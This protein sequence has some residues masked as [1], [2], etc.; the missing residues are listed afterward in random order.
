MIRI[1]DE[2]EV[3]EAELL[4]VTSRSSGPGGQNV[5]KVSTRVT[6]RFDVARSPALSEDERRLVR[7]RLATRINRDG[8]LSVTS[9]RHRTQAGNRRAAQERFVELMAEALTVDP[10]RR[11][12]RTPRAARARRLDEK[13][14][15]ARLKQRRSR[16]DPDRE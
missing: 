14:R 16:V 2:L 7:E 10:E 4:F 13:R 6:L 9:R 11:P 3:D 8:V 15:R 1:N 12:T 5:N